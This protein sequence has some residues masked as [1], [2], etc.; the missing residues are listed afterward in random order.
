MR[1]GMAAIA[2]AKE[3]HATLWDKVRTA[4]PTLAVFKAAELLPAKCHG[5]A[6]GV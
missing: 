2:G 4:S 3:I 6:S 1:E 5:A